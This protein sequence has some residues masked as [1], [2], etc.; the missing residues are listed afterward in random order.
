MRRITALSSRLLFLFLLNTGSALAADQSS[1]PI[2]NSSPNQE[3]ARPTQ[4]TPPKE[5]TTTDPTREPITKYESFLREESKRQVDF[6]QS[7]VNQLFNLI[8]IV[9]GGL[10]IVIGLLGYFGFQ[11]YR[12]T[13]LHIRNSSAEIAEKEIKEAIKKTSQEYDRR[14]EKYLNLTL[15][16]FKGLIDVEEIRNAWV[17]GGFEGTDRLKGRIFLWVD[18][19]PLGIG[20][21]TTFLKKFDATVVV[22]K[23]VEGGR[24]RLSQNKFHIVITNMNRPEGHEGG[25][26]FVKELRKKNLWDG[27][28]LIFT[29]SPNMDEALKLRCSKLNAVVATDKQEFFKELDNLL[30]SNR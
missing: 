11:N 17:G 12:E 16:V 15:D 2:S 3:L 14:A 19:D 7:S 25:F 1:I 22:E 30:N 27:P 26:N 9:G 29:K 23:T 18:D 8:T 6:L 10:G 20:L 28:V 24:R 4:S 13:L 21:F 5:Q